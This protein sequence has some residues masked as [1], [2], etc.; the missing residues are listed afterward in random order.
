MAQHFADDGEA[1]AACNTDR[2]KGMA[3]VMQSQGGQASE[4]TDPPPRLFDID[5]G[6]FLPSNND[7]RVAV[8]ARQVG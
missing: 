1:M 3:K 8:D 5:Q 6:A 7:V 2:R 4:A